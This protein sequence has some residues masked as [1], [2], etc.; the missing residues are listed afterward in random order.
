MVLIDRLV[1]HVCGNPGQAFSRAGSM[2]WNLWAKQS[3]E[4]KKELYI[5]IVSEKS[6]KFMEMFSIF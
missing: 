6:Y 2:T 3:L 1:P 5:N 4:E